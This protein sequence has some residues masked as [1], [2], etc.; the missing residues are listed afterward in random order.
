[1]STMH[2]SAQQ[3][4]SN[5]ARW[6]Q[7]GSDETNMSDN[8]RLFSIVGGTALALWGLSRTPK[9]TLILL[10]GGLYAVYRGLNGH[11]HIYEQLG[12]DHGEQ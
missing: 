6:P 9:G 12:I 1:M 10:A 11:C 8:E 5:R 3:T 7:M 2:Q 4:G